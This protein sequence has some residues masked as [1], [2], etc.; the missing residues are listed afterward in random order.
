MGNKIRTSGTGHTVINRNSGTVNI[1][2]AVACYCRFFLW[3]RRICHHCLNGG[4]CYCWTGWFGRRYYCHHCQPAPIVACTH[5]CTPDPRIA[6]LQHQIALLKRQ[7]RGVQGST[8]RLFGLYNRLHTILL[9]QRPVVQPCTR[10]HTVTNTTKTVTRYLFLVALLIGGIVG[11]LLGWAAHDF[12]VVKWLG[13]E[14]AWHNR[15]GLACLGA[16]IGGVL[17]V[18]IMPGRVERTRNGRVI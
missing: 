6:Q 18:M 3:W 11:A 15:A 2:M 16:A 12:G 7:M 14:S 13:F 10:P 4:S 8:N 1:G 17:G 9:T 5:T